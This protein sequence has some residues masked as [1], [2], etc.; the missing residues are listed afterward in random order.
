MT[1]PLIVSSILGGVL[2]TMNPVLP[3]V[4]VFFTTLLAILLIVLYIRDP[5]EV[6]I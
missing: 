2:Y 4:F 6:E 5:H 1:I 3:W